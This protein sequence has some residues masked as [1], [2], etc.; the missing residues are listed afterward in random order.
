MNSR[1]V[2]P[3]VLLTGSAA[4]AA[5]LGWYL[6]ALLGRTEFLARSTSLAPDVIVGFHLL[7]VSAV[8]ASAVAQRHVKARHGWAI[9]SAACVVEITFFLLNVFGKVWHFQKDEPESLY[10]A[11]VHLIQ[12]LFR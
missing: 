6:W 5:G 3:H 7:G 1:S 12:T 8:A 4:A 9:F 11:V 10:A 2:V